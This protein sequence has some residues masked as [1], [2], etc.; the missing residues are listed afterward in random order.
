MQPLEPQ[1][2]IKPLNTIK[3]TYSPQT[4]IE[5]NNW[6]NIKSATSENGYKLILKYAKMIEEK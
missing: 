3:I 6:A 1:V 4:G 5:H 2:S